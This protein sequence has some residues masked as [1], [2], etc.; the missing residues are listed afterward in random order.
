M[1]EKKWVTGIITS[2]TLL[3]RVISPFITGWGPPC[4]VLRICFQWDPCTASL[5]TYIWLMLYW[6]NVCKYSIHG[7][8]ESKQKTIC[9]SV[10]SELHVVS[11]EIFEVTNQN[12][13]SVTL[14]A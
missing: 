8:Y 2:I 5:S 12:G 10:L 6:I 9:P 1:A 11:E 14:R 4:I 7:S 13:S 3:I